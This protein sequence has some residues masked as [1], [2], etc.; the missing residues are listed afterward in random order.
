MII[1]DFKIEINEKSFNGFFADSIQI[2][3]H[4]S[5]E[6]KTFVLFKSNPGSS[7]HPL[8]EDSILNDHL[9]EDINDKMH[10]LTD[11]IAF[12]HDKNYTCCLTLIKI[13]TDKSRAVY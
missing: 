1:Q 13:S 4:T 5:E 11:T 7:F 6:N 9:N 10:Y 8:I 3:F 2:N 12:Y